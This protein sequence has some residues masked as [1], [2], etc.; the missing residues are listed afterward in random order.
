MGFCR[1]KCAFAPVR[2]TTLLLHSAGGQGKRSRTQAVCRLF[3]IEYINSP[4]P[5]LQVRV[6][7]WLC[8]WKVQQNESSKFHQ[9]IRRASCPLTPADM[10]GTFLGEDA[11]GSYYYNLTDDCY[12]FRE[13]KNS[14]KDSLNWEVATTSEEQVHELTDALKA[15]VTLARKRSRK[16]KKKPKKSDPRRVSDDSLSRQNELVVDI[17][18]EMLPRV[19]PLVQARRRREAKRLAILAPRKRSSRIARVEEQRAEREAREAKER[20]EI[21]EREAAEEARR[22]AKRAARDRAARASRR[23]NDSATGQ[24]REEMAAE[25]ARR[26]REDRAMRR[27][28]RDEEAN[29]LKQ[30]AIAQAMQE[31]IAQAERTRKAEA[32]RVLRDQRQRARLALRKKRKREALERAAAQAAEEQRLMAERARQQMLAAE[33]LRAM[34]AEMQHRVAAGQPPRQPYVAASAQQPQQPRKIIYRPMPGY[35]PPRQGFA[36]QPQPQPQFASNVTAVTAAQ[37]AAVAASNVRVQQAGFG[38]QVF[39]ASAQPTTYAQP[40]AYAQPTTY[41]QPTAYAQPAPLK[42]NSSLSQGTAFVA[43]PPMQRSGVMQYNRVGAPASS[44]RMAPVTAPVTA[45][46]MAPVTAQASSVQPQQAQQIWARYPPSGS[47]Q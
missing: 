4:Q 23:R 26:S 31:S 20:A 11:R 22:A 14:T 28:L 17:Q 32:R 42:N 16:A 5:H 44:M 21:E 1:A 45:P 40:T 43:Q 12:I 24:R 27:R 10:R 36:P 37:Y 38:R 46:V 41:A 25:R 30:E 33:K 34:Q 3:I 15:E 6:L 9:T 35:E 7:Y 19:L 2:K 8:V 47:Q 13:G 18:D 29:R 39:P